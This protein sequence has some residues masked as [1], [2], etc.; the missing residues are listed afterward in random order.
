MRVFGGW[1]RIEGRP[2]QRVQYGATKKRNL[3]S[4]RQVI[5]ES[6]RGRRHTERISG[7]RW[8]HRDLGLA[9]KR[10]TTTDL[11]GIGGLEHE[12][13][14]YRRHRKIKRDV[15]EN[16]QEHSATT[17]HGRILSDGTTIAQWF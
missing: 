10:A 15:E 9:L 5:P 7:E 17:L 11:N 14:R 13:A 8:Q 1:S 6:N 16:G 4:R 2:W 12:G 3:A